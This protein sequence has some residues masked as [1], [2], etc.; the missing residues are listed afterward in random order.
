[1]NGSNGLNQCALVPLHHILS[2]MA[3]IHV[4]AVVD[5]KTRCQIR[6][7]VLIQL[8]PGKGITPIVQDVY[9]TVCRDSQ[10]VEE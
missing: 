7:G 5:T 6:D 8:T 1:M 9:N 10:R 4:L 3:H 2:S